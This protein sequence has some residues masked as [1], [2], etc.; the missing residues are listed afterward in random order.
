MSWNTEA[1]FDMKTG[2]KNVLPVTDALIYEDD[3]LIDKKSN[4]KINL[5][6]TKIYLY[7]SDKNLVKKLN[8]KTDINIILDSKKRNIRHWI[9][10]LRNNSTIKNSILF[11]SPR[12]E[13]LF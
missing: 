12:L 9:F 2:L 4:S 5:N 8:T 13:Y 6:D 11:L 10:L 1:I 3:Y 7:D